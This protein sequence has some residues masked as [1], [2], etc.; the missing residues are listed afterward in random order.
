MELYR[1]DSRRSAIY[2]LCVCYCIKELKGLC[3]IQKIAATQAKKNGCTKDEI[4]HRFR[5]KTKQQQDTY[6]ST[7]V[8]YADAKVCGALCKGG[9]IHYHLKEESGISSNWICHHVVPNIKRVYGPVVAKVLGHALMLRIFDDTQALV[10][11][12]DTVSSVKELYPRVEGM[13]L[14]DVL[15]FLMLLMIITPHLFFLSLSQ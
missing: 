13:L 6:V 9:P 11:D 8:A 3:L 5:W 12:V 4:D 15:C 1:S 10:C 2:C 14:M 7:D